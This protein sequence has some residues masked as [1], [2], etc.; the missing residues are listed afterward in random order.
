MSRRKRQGLISSRHALT[1]Q[2]LAFVRIYSAF[3]HTNAT[4]AYRRA[5]LGQDDDGN[6]FD[7]SRTG[8]LRTDKPVTAKA[9]QNRAA[10]LIRQD[11][12]AAYIAELKGQA[13]DH[14]R[15]TLTDAVLFTKDQTALKAAEKV[16]QEEDKLGFRDAVEQWGEILAAIG[17]EVVV[18]LPDGR[19]AVVPFG[20][21]FPT[22]E[23]A[24]PPPDV[25]TKTIKTLEA[26]RD[27][28]SD[29]EATD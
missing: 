6:W 15:Q 22:F 27:A 16:L 29:R 11:H 8:D 23:G 26:M 1:E 20:R 5:Y 14:A 2:E 4:E 12:I 17:T 28:A 13:G 7:L 24:T 9:A 19:E 10:A 18:A 21:L 25:I 3:G